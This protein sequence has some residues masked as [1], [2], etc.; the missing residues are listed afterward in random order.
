MDY[1]TY[2]MNLF[3]LSLLF[4]D[5]SAGSQFLWGNRG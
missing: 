3:L 1:L 5:G 2:F 4:I